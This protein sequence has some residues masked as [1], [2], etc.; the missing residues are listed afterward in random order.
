MLIASSTEVK[1]RFG[2]FM[3]KAQKEP[4]TVEKTGKPYAVLMSIEDFRRLQAIEDAYWGRLGDEG[5]ASGF[6][7]PEATM[8]SIRRRLDAIEAR[9]GSD[10]SIERDTE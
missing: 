7:G 9:S 6:L 10:L 3:D 8:A 5:I 1:N 4:I 2:E